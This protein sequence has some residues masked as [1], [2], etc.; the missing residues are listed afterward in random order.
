V[1][2]TLSKAYGIAGLRVGFAIALPDVI[3]EIAVYRPPGSVSV[4]SVDVGAA[5]LTDPNIAADRVETIT[6]ERGRFVAALR[7]AGWDA[8]ASVT[9]FVL[10][11]FPSAAAADAAAEGL[12]SRGLIPR[13]FPSGHPLDH[14]IRLTVRD[15]EQDD[16][17]VAA[18]RELAGRS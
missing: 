17:L 18:A 5:L 11:E 13:T 1:L 7:E 14:C 9:N 12:L 3:E 15:R 16:R 6:A 8:K 4:V 10:V 2:R